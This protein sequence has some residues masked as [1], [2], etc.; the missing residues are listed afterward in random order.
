MAWAMRLSEVM[1]PVPP[2]CSAKRVTASILGPMDPAAK[3]WSREMARISATVTSPIGRAWA[4]PQS[5]TAESTSVAMTRTSAEVCRAIRAAVRSLSITASMP[6]RVPSLAADGGDAPAAGAHHEVALGQQRV[7]GRAV[8]ALERLRRGHHPAP[9]AVGHL[10]EVL[11]VLDQ[12]P[13]LV[14]GQVATDRLGRGR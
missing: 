4:V 13:R 9:A 6:L 11:A 1:M 3:P 2:L 8:E 7:G 10:D 14:L 12:H 5:V